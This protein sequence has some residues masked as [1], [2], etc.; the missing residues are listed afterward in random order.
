MPRRLT[1]LE[2]AIN[3]VPTD[4]ELA[5]LAAEVQRE[6]A[7]S[8]VAA[9][10]LHGIAERIRV[11]QSSKSGRYYFDLMSV[12]KIDCA[13]R[14]CVRSIAS[15]VGA[16]G[17]LGVVGETPL[18]TVIQRR[19]AIVRRFLDLYERG[20]VGEIRCWRPKNR[21][22]P[23]PVRAPAQAEL[24]FEDKIDRL[25]SVLGKIQHLSPEVQSLVAKEM[26]R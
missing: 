5:A 26:L 24:P 20:T 10:T 1:R 11:R 3:H 25:L 21:P 13:G 2:E 9:V 12:E 14:V 16:R 19:N 7:R 22:A 18:S 4:D 8:G 17:F 6:V 23:A 15:A